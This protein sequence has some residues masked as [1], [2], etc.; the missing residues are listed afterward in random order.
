MNYKQNIKAFLRQLPS[1]SIT[2]Q[3]AFLATAA[4]IAQGRA[5]RQITLADIKRNWQKAII[6][7]K[8]NPALYS[9]A[10]ENGWIDPVGTGLLKVSEQGFQHLIDIT[11][12]DSSIDTPNDKLFVFGKKEAHHFD[13]FLRG[14]F[15]NAK[16]RVWIADSYV[17]ET[18]FD[19][20]LDSI[21]KTVE[22]KLLYGRKLGSFELRGN[23]FNKMYTKYSAKRYSA[24]HDRFIVVDEDGFVLGPS[25]KDATIN[26]PALVVKLSYREAK[27]LHKFFKKI[28]DKAK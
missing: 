1:S 14:I 8:Y 21:P 28:W 5:D 3:L 2:G 13:K 11:A 17:D 12:A 20:V 9:R 6:G 22:V 7:R 19:L 18:I 23:R 26:S 24:L 27:N 4:Y 25:I 10:Q 16:V 15:A